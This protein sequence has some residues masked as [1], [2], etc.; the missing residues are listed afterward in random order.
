MQYC[1]GHPGCS[2]K[3]TLIAPVE[4]GS[5]PGAILYV[6]SDCMR[7]CRLRPLVPAA[8]GGPVYE[9]RRT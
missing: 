5:G 7:I 6:C 8:S 1:S 2:N 4:T 3:P 9:S